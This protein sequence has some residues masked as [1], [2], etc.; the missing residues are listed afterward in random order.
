MLLA[1]LLGNERIATDEAGEE[2]VE[3]KQHGWANQRKRLTQLALRDY[4]AYK[5]KMK[6][7]RYGHN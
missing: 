4:E 5:E 3:V 7:D 1:K 6:N 2:L